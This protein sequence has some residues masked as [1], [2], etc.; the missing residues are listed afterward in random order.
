MS[1]SKNFIDADLAYDLCNSDDETNLSNGEKLSISDA[2]HLCMDKLQRVDIRFIAKKSGTWAEIVVDKLRGVAIFQNPLEFKDKPYNI[3]DGWVTREVYLSGFIPEKLKDAQFANRH[4]PG[5]FTVNVDALSELCAEFKL[6]YEDIDISL[7]APFVPC[8]I[9][10]DFI[11]FL[12]RLK[13]T[14]KVEYNSLR[15]RF[16]VA[17]SNQDDM[18]TIKNHPIYSTSKMHALE[19]ITK[20][21]NAVT[22]KVYDERYDYHSGKKI[23]IFNKEET[24]KVLE[25][26]RRI[27]ASFKSYLA[28]SKYRSR[29]V[30]E[31][32]YKQFV[33]F[34]NCTIDGSYLTLPDLNPNISLFPRQLN[35]VARALISDSNLLFAHR[36]GAGKTYIIIVTAH[37]LYRTGKSK[38]NLVVVPNNILQDFENAHK[39]L[40]GNDNIL[41]I[42]PK[43]FTPDKRRNTLSKIQHGDYVAVYMPYSCFDKITMSKA[44]KVK[45]MIDEIAEVKAA[46]AVASTCTERNSLESLSKKKA[47][48]LQKFK[49]EYVDPEWQ[50]FDALK[51]DTLFVDEAHNFKSITIETHCDNI[52][53]MSSKG[54]K[55]ANNMLEKVHSVNRTIFSTGTPLTNSL[56]ELFVL[57]T[58]L[59]PEQ[60]KFRNRK[61]DSFDMWLNTFAESETDVEC[62]I[63]Q[64]LRTTTRFTAFHNLPE[65]MGMF[66]TVCDFCFDIVDEELPDFDGYTNKVIKKSPIQA[67]YIKG[68]AKRAE[69]VRQHKIHRKDDNYLKITT[70]GRKCT[71]A[72][73]L[74]GL[75]DGFENSKINTCA[76]KVFD[77]NQ[78]YPDKA[79]VVFCDVGTPKEGF[80]VYDELKYQL[81]KLGI[82]AKEIAF[83]HDAKNEK[84]RNRLFERVNNAEV[85]V[86]IGSTEK[87]G[88]G[89]NIQR[90]L[91]ALHHLSVP[92]RPADMEQ[93]EGRILRHGNTCDEVE[94]YRYIT[95][96][97]FDSY[98]WQLLQNKQKFISSFL[99]GTSTVRNLD[100]LS[101]SVLSYA[102]LKALAIGNK[103]IRQRVETANKL[104]HTRIA[105]RQRRK[106]LAEISFSI[107][108]LNEKIPVQKKLIRTTAADIELYATSRKKI[109]NDERVA[110]G[111]ELIY[112]LQGNYYKEEQNLF[113][114]YQGFDVILPSGMNV[115]H[116]YIYVKSVNGGSYYLEM[117]YEKPRG[118]CLRIDI[119][120][121]HLDERLANQKAELSQMRKQLKDAKADL[122]LGNPY[123]DTIEALEGEL[124]KIDNKIKEES[125]A[126]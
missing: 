48:K 10:S 45:K 47:D 89:V 17:V 75:Y 50:C 124:E 2:F 67:E 51:I 71:I 33:G 35:S 42:T 92:W 13:N 81:V 20:T 77:I 115:E 59:Q 91:K 25:I 41:V 32:Y 65:L 16:K 80:N 79:Q 4:F 38:K 114:T 28:S 56:A 86:I 30:K 57:Q 37:E 66:S 116:P 5:R 93:R 84:Q 43:M 117:E 97:T 121:D 58:F 96:G 111:E 125:E 94:I 62:D 29:R 49:D 98:S 23:R 82:P 11:E 70:D 63:T 9:Y 54:S 119:L 60:L 88:V 112:A 3:Y 44:Y 72:P 113:D 83:I 39:L 103:L 101:N 76:K 87:L 107:E 126:A 53:G 24:Q 120:L 78:N 108:K 12:L 64:N 123:P 46:I 1:Y 74:L 36:V 15:A 100:D 73:E 95:E 104:E 109:P 19:I 122:A 102:E 31:S 22:L 6:A 7:G 99:S 68:L 110:F 105:S 85:K 18:R 69:F 14:P 52:V 34:N 26:Q 55:R 27:T 40:Y 90:N 8:D 118:C 106:Q 21:M 61:I